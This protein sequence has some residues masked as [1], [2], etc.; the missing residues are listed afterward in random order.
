MDNALIQKARQGIALLFDG[1]GMHLCD[2]LVAISGFYIHALKR[3]TSED[4]VCGKC[5]A[6]NF[7]ALLL[8]QDFGACTGDHKGLEQ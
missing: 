6:R 5:T 8:D 3:L 7:A 2:G 4:R 1:L